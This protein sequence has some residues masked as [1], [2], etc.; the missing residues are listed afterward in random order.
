MQESQGFLPSDGWGCQSQM[1][2]LGDYVRPGVATMRRAQ[3][4]GLG[5][6]SEPGSEKG[7]SPRTVPAL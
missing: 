7:R 6:L 3:P 1:E 5:T 4:V 2:K